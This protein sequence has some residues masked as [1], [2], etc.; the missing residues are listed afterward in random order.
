MPGGCF[1]GPAGFT[2]GDEG[3]QLAGADTQPREPVEPSGFQYGGVNARGARL[4]PTTRRFGGTYGESSLSVDGLLAQSDGWA[5]VLERGDG[6]RRAFSAADDPAHDIISLSITLEANNLS[7][8]QVAVPPDPSLYEWSFSEVV[9][10]Y[11]G[12]RLFHGVLL[13]VESGYGD[14]LTLSGFGRFWHATHGNIKAHYSSM[15]AW[16]AINK[17]WDRVGDVT[18]G[19]VRGFAIRPPADREVWLSAEGQT[20]DGSPL[21]AV[22]QL[23]DVASMTFTLDHAEEAAVATSFAAGTETRTAAWRSEDYSAGLDPTGYYNRVVVEGAKAPPAYPY[24]RYRGSAEVSEAERIGIAHGAELEYWFTDPEIQT[25]GKCD[26]RA[27]AKLNEL[28]SAYSL[29]GDLALT[30]TRAVPGYRYYIPEFQDAAPDIMTP[31]VLPLQTLEYSF[32]HAEAG[33]T[34]N[35]KD[36]D[37]VV[38]ELRGDDGTIAFQDAGFELPAEFDRWG[39]GV[40]GEGVWGGIGS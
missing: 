4:G 20:V 36:Y 32:G 15:P 1:G 38:G 8:W 21:D 6:K 11:N 25:P 17:L 29:T 35:F 5:L 39:D 12:E 24:E 13:P 22:K 14:E 10:G 26:V 28:R 3:A 33:T 7:D 23:H 19:E 16:Q 9:I 31:V 18:G 37:G 30:P 40:W 34:L 27:Q 2:Y